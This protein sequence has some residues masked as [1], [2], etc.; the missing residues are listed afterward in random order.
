MEDTMLRW[1]LLLLVVALIAAVLGF[2]GVASVAAG[3]ARIL[4]WIFIIL[5][6]LALIFGRGLDF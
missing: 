4:F 3:F 2:G 1:A 6:I 5:F